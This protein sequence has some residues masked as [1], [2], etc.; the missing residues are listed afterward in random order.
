MCNHFFDPWL[1]QSI[2]RKPMCAEAHY[3]SCRSVRNAALVQTKTFRLNIVTASLTFATGANLRSRDLLLPEQVLA[4]VV[5][6][7]YPSKAPHHKVHTC[8]AQRKHGTATTAGMQLCRL[9]H[10][11]DP[12]FDGLGA[13][14]AHTALALATPV[15]AGANCSEMLDGCLSEQLSCWHDPCTQRRGTC[16]QTAPRAVSLSSIFL[17]WAALRV[18]FPN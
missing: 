8:V 18:S 2:Q 7:L 14:V 9:L 6:V 11:K 10:G 12:R 15:A 16:V 17:G 3:S 13:A 1:T 4:F 5:V